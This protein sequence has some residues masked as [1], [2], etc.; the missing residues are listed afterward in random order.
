MKAFDPE[1]NK[2]YTFL[3]CEQGDKI[4]VRVKKEIAKRMEQLIGVKLNDENPV[5]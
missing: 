4:D 3:G 1:Q 2:V 5:K